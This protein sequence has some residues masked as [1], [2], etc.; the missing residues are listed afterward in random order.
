LQKAFEALKGFYSR[1]PRVFAAVALVLV[2]TGIAAVYLSVELTSAPAFCS[3]CHEMKHAYRTWT[4]SPHYNVDIAK[5]KK[6]ATCRDCHLPPWSKPFELLWS[7]AYHGAK[8]VTRHFTDKEEM[9][10]AGYYFNMK[11]HAGKTL[12]NASCLKCHSD[13]Y[14]KEYEGYE[15]I[16][17]GLKGNANMKCYACHEDIAHKTYVPEDIK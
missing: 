17:A 16:H 3:S 12:S 10:H 13:I 4:E 6:R 8:D 5:G 14:K 9:K 7:K 15:N 11:A 2:V 1:H